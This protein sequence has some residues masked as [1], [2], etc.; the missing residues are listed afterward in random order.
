MTTNPTTPQNDTWPDDEDPDFTPEQ[1]KH[2]EREERRERRA[3]AALTSKSKK[4][5]AD[6]LR[7]EGFALRNGI[8]FMPFHEV[9][10]ASVHYFE[11]FLSDYDPGYLT[12]RQPNPLDRAPSWSLPPERAEIE[13]E[14]GGAAGEPAPEPPAAAPEGDE[15]PL[16]TTPGAILRGIN[17]HS[18]RDGFKE[19]AIVAPSSRGGFLACLYFDAAFANS[20]KVAGWFHDL[21]ATSVVIDHTLYSDV[22]D[23]RDGLTHGCQ[24]WTVYFD[25]PGAGE[26][27]AE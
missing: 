26:G 6:L 7:L 19:C 3:R 27:E 22:D 13:G 8:I 1:I 18:W 24:A 25:L 23:D 20:A 9:L 16:A 11:Q 21:G 17:A 4:V 14:A 10:L 15:T 12:D 2:F 5:H